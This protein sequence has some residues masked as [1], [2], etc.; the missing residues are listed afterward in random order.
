MYKK[1]LVAAASIVVLAGLTV[2]CGGGQ[3]SNQDG[4]QGQGSN[5]KTGQTEQGNTGQGKTE[6]AKKARTGSAREVKASEGVVGRVD[7]E[8]NFVIVKPPEQKAML[9]R[10]NPDKVKVTLDGNEAG[11]QDIEKGQ[12]A[13]VSYVVVKPPKA[14]NDR[15]EARVISVKPRGAG[16]GGGTTG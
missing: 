3:D 9:F 6:K 5:P 15:N 11:V 7:N 4:S 1:I 2:G 12:Q 14:K 13:T 16:S 8:K 10:Y